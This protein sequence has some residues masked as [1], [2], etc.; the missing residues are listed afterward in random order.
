MLS[1]IVPVHNEAPTLDALL[2]L[3]EAVPL[4]KEILLLDD[5]STDGS[6]E[7]V[8]ARE[9]RPSYR[10]FVNEKNRGKGYCV[11]LGI[12]EARG[13]VV[14]FQ[15]AD[16]EYSPAELPG[17]VAPIR[18]GRAD[19]VYGARFLDPAGPV[20]GFWHFHGNRWLT[21]LS[22]LT[23]GLYLNDMETC[24]KVFRADVIKSIDITCDDFG[25]EPEITAKVARLP[26]VRFWQ[27]PI[28]YAPRSYAEGKKINWKDGFK[29][30]WYI[31]K[32]GLDR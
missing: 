10:V 19:V 28:S 17:L 4:E 21:Q 25:T 15:D 29:A 2:A 20:H 24:Y 18:E 5:G 3:V 14:V 32:F 23:T 27:A 26:G 9:G 16:L 30:V 11:R 7:L 12:R 6:T 8:R 31:A 13:D 22:N 1:L